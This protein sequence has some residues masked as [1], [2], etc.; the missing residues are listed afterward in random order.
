MALFKKFKHCLLY[1][2]WLWT[3]SRNSKMQYG[4]RTYFGIFKHFVGSWPDVAVFLK[5]KHYVV[6]F[7]VVTLQYSGN[8]TFAGCAVF[9]KFENFCRYLP[10]CERISEILRFCVEFLTTFLTTF[11]KFKHVK[12]IL[13]CCWSYFTWWWEFK[14]VMKQFSVEKITFWESSTYVE[15]IPCWENIM[16]RKF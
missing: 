7:P 11:W 5:F 1:Y 6:F 16:L 13:V 14:E 8:S 3:Y 12:W 15:K 4:I 9:W 2:C 10:I